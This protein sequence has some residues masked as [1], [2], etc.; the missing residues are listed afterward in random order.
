MVFIEDRRIPILHLRIQLN[1]S[2]GGGVR[3][4]SCYVHDHSL[5]EWKLFGNLNAA[6][7]FHST[8]LLN[9]DLWMTGGYGSRD[10]SSN[11]QDFHSYF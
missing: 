5:N 9:G 1:F 7:Y 8:S 4:S 2:T 3:L 11:F 10:V 6:R